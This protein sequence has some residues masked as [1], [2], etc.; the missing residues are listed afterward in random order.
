MRF[1][2]HRRLSTS[3]AGRGWF[4][5]ALFALVVATA[6]AVGLP[7]AEV[8]A[9]DLDRLMELSGVSPQLEWIA[10]NVVAQVRLKRAEFGRTRVTRI[11]SASGRERSTVKKAS[12][13]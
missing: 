9:D 8:P 2:I 10:P 12:S 3:I 13:Q 7:V 5:G 11:S 4:A 6:P 1:P